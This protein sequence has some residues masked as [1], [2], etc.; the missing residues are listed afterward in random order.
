MQQSEINELIEGEV[1][2]IESAKDE[3]KSYSAELRKS[4]TLVSRLFKKTKNLKKQYYI[5]I[6]EKELKEASQR[7]EHLAEEITKLKKTFNESKV[8]LRKLR[9]VKRKLEDLKSRK[10]GVIKKVPE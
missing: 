3:I 6:A 2:L 7:C 10:R 5:D 4:V 9:V 8:K 1:Q